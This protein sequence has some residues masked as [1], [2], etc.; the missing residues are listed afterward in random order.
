MFLKVL[1]IKFGKIDFFPLNYKLMT[2]S[3]VLHS[4]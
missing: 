1:H 3:F 4:D 2:K